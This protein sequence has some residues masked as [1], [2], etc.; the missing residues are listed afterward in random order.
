MYDFSI[1][2][3][4]KG[5]RKVTVDVERFAGLNVCGFSPIEVFTEILSHC[6]G[7]KSSLLV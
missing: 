4:I 6:P 5:Y 2:Q 3:I 7:Q 1:L